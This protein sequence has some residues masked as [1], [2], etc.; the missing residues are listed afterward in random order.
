MLA[1]Q[2]HFHSTFHIRNAAQSALQQNKL[3]APSALNEKDIKA[4]KKNI[5]VT[6]HKKYSETKIDRMHTE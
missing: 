5:D 3:H 1:E 2:L 6:Q 4:C